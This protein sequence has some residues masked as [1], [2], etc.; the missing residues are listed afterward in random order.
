VGVAWG[1]HRAAAAALDAELGISSG[2]ASSADGAAWSGDGAAAASVGEPASKRLRVDE[3]GAAAAAPGS[4]A[5]L[6]QQQQPVPLGVTGQQGQLQLAQQQQQQQHIP[7]ANAAIFAALPPVAA[8]ADIGAQDLLPS[9]MAEHMR[10][11]Q[12]WQR[13]L[14]LRQP[15]RLWPAGNAQ[16]GSACVARECERALMEAFSGSSEW[17]VD[18][19]V[20]HLFGGKAGSWC[21]QGT[22]IGLAQGWRIHS[23]R[24]V[25]VCI[26]R[27]Y[28]IGTM[29]E[30]LEKMPAAYVLSLLTPCC[31]VQVRVLQ[32]RSSAQPAA[33]ESIRHCGLC[34]YELRHTPAFTILLLLCYVFSSCHTLMQHQRSVQW[35]P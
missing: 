25:A 5:Q 9:V 10:S 14:R 33:S 26:L 7:R 30:Q 34:C 21:L 24:L 28:V 4:T 17:D 12:L 32:H 6:P 19:V 20:N 13:T 23:R 35:Q 1:S 29:K 27:R 31:I 15:G 16:Y 2:D 18:V 3:S 8:A 11:L 22:G